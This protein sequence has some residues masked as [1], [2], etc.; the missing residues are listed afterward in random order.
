[1]W[2]L[3]D[4]VR[5]VMLWGPTIGRARWQSMATW[6]GEQLWAARLTGTYILSVELLF[7]LALV[8]ARA[9]WFFVASAVALHVATWLLLGL[10]YWTWAATVL[11]VFVDWPALLD[12]WR[13]R[14]GAATARAGD[15]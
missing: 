3:G 6:V 4:N 12:R 13:A 14:G 10:D 8:W 7:P 5:Y 15:G 2:A 1:D 9:R 11:V